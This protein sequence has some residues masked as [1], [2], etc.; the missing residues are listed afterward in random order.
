MAIYPRNAAS[1][2][3]TVTL[4]GGAGNTVPVYDTN[5][6]FYFTRGD[7]CFVKIYLTGVTGSAGAGTGVINIALPINS[8]STQLYHGCGTMRSDGSIWEIKATT[9]GSTVEIVKRTSATALANATGADQS[10]TSNKTINLEF[11]YQI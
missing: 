7:L 4:V 11:W 5:D 8:A 1:F 9:V 6:G 3:P 10:G 2:T